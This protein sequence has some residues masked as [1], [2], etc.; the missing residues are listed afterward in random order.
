MSQL[1]G[2]PQNIIAGRDIRHADEFWA[3]NEDI[4]YP[5]ESLV[6]QWV[7]E[8]EF[9]GWTTPWW[10]RSGA[11]M[12]DAGDVNIITQA[13]WWGEAWNQGGASSRLAFVGVARDYAGNALPGATVR[14][15]R[16]SSVELV[17]SVVSDENGLYV[18]TTP[19]VD[20][21]FLVV[22]GTSGATPVSGASIDTVIPG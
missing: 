19:Y 11:L 13:P 7:V 18:A 21:H 20:G 5:Q 14:C 10:P 2:Q 9:Q 16:T 6:S 22:H 3:G 8:R 15:F 17:S 12:G 1:L 4:V